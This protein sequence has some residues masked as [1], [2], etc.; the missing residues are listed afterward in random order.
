MKLALTIF[1]TFLGA[2]WGHGQTTSALPLVSPRAQIEEIRPL[3]PT[4]THFVVS[5]RASSELYSTDHRTRVISFYPRVPEMSLQ[6]RTPKGELKT[7]RLRV[8]GK[9]Y[10]RPSPMP[11]YD[12]TASP[13]EPIGTIELTD[14]PR[15]NLLRNKVNAAAELVVPG[16]TSPLQP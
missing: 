1:C 11:L 12:V 7:T 2:I 16:H 13:W 5:F 14:P 8:R 3:P 4:R 9:L 10:H 6:W 15:I